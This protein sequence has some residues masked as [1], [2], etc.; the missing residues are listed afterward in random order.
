MMFPWYFL[1]SFFFFS[2]CLDF[3]VSIAD[4]VFF[5]SL[6]FLRLLPRRIRFHNVCSLCDSHPRSYICYCYSLPVCLFNIFVEPIVREH[7]PGH[8]DVLLSVLQSNNNKERAKQRMR[9]PEKKTN[10]RISMSVSSWKTTTTTKKR[11]MFEIRIFNDNIG[12]FCLN[13]K[14]EKKE[15]PAEWLT[16][17]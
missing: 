15:D 17:L 11:S 7:Q 2:V 16:D 13:K 9:F 12:C 1:C 14:G 3:A 6:I 4:L 5:F 10:K 8:P